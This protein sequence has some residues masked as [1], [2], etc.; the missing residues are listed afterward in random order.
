MSDTVY[1]VGLIGCGGRGNLH[2]GAITKVPRLKVEALC[3][4]IPRKAMWMNE[5][6]G[7]DAT[8]YEDY[9]KML[10][11]K[12]LDLVI[13]CLW[14]PLHLPVIKDCVNAGIR[15]LH[16]EKPVAPTWNGYLESA[17]IANSKGVKLTYAHQR[18]Y[19]KGN[20]LTRKL[21]KD[22]VFGKI[23][24]MELFSPPHLLDCGTHTFDQ[25]F[26]FNDESPV[27]WVLGNGDVTNSISY[28]EVPAE[29]FFVGHFEYKNGV[30]GS[31][32]V[33][34]MK[35]DGGDLESG[36]RVIGD[37]GFIDVLWDGII[38]RAVVYD[39]PS[40]QVEELPAYVGDA[41]ATQ[42]PDMLQGVVDSL[43]GD[44]PAEVDYRR[45][46]R[47]G[48]VIFAFYES[49]RQHKRIY[50]PLIGQGDCPIADM[51]AQSK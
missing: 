4:I 48:E 2:A 41:G 12:E 43:D 9:H 42:I 44:L 29:S 37:K 3:D 47:A 51:I 35:T 50:L 33:G 13:V 23:Q 31:I 14:T 27:T 10:A 30:K 20:L 15:Y 34:R 45:A 36:V 22:G 18:R 11:E 24:R 19:A 7:F 39:D 49:M 46:I 28:F 1:K 16:S 17:Y 21:I 5:R 6:Y 25:A 8:I 26:S 32:K 38:T 40:F